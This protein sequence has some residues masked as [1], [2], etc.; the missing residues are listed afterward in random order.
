MNRKILIFGNFP[1]NLNNE[2]IDTNHYAQ[3]F[4]RN[5][6]EV[7]FVTA[8]AYLLDFFIPFY[9]DR[10]LI[11]KNFLKNQIEIEKGLIQHTPLAMIPLRNAP[12][13]RGGFNLSMFSILFRMLDISR[14]EYDICIVSQGFMLLWASL[15][16][17]KLFIYRYNDI[18]DGFAN[19]P[20]VLKE[21]EREF[22]NKRCNLII[23]VNEML[24]D[25]LKKMYPEFSNIQILPNG[26]DLDLFSNSKP[27][28][29]LML[30]KKKKVVFCGGIDFWVDTEL[31]YH[32]AQK[33]KDIV[34]VLIGPAKVNID[35]I[36]GLP[37]VVYLGPKK[38]VEIPP[39]IKACDIGLIPFKKERLTQFVDKPLKYYEYLASGL[40][41]VASGIAPAK[42]K[43]PYLRCFKDRELL[44]EYIDTMSIMRQEERREVQ[45]VVKQSS[46][47]YIFEILEDFIEEVMKRI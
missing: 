3:Y 37:N 34:L 40:P 6:D 19:H 4:A 31:L 41:V 7:D 21:Y 36:L 38:Y 46:W 14:K 45:E 22:I 42:D 27:D 9:K 20:D 30:I 1:F 26:V 33:L 28:E 2:F 16:K 47:R 44:I 32:L 17:A 11:L 29:S 8:P 10:R 15:I 12:I 5:G 18:L 35:R 25:E 13:F 39:L 24:R 23:T 43:N